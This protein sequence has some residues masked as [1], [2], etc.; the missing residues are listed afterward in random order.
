MNIPEK[1]VSFN[2]IETEVL[3]IVHQLGREALQAMLEEWDTVLMES[4]DKGVYRHKG[5]HKTTIKTTMGEVEYSRAV[6]EFWDNGAKIGHSYLLD[7]AI[8]IS[9]SGQLSELLCD[10]IVQASCAM[11]YR[12]AARAVSEMT[13]QTISHTAAWNVVQAVGKQLEAHE[14]RAT[15]LA[16]KDVGAGTIEAKVLFE[17]HDGVWLDLQGKDRLK[18]GSSKEM[19]LAIAYDGAEKKGKNRYILTNKVACANFEGANDFMER[20]EG[21]I[22]G[23]CNVDEISMRFVNGDGAKW[24]RQSLVDET[25]HFQLDPYHRNRAITEYVADPSIRKLITEILYSKDVDLLLHVI[26]VEALSAY[27][28]KAHENYMK[29]HSYFQNNKDGLVPYNQRGLDIPEPPEGKIYRR[30][31][32]AESNI[33]T[34]IGNRMKSRRRCWSIEGGN[35]MARLLCLKHTGRLRGI[36]G[37]LSATVLPE[38]YAEEVKVELSATKVP[39]RVG[40]G[41]NGFHHVPIPSSQ[42]WLKDLAAIKTFAEVRF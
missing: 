33:F 18:Y 10:Q 1:F 29:L 24:I 17:E 25:T 42:K 40:K 39:Q 20:K 36:L 31:G 3:K 19:K 7:E 37:S 26:E 23:A 12:E 5:K 21:V 30:M 32:A 16:A 15:E 4:R 35:N 27:D 6:Y 8:G 14:D 13:G 2:D 9:C 38:R 28:E 41:Y 34:I 11:P 22:A